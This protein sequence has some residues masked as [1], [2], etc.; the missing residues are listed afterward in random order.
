MARLFDNFELFMKLLVFFA[1]SDQETSFFFKINFWEDISPFLG[2]TDTRVSCVLSR[3]ETS[4][5]MEFNCKYILK[6]TLSY[7]T[8]QQIKVYLFSTVKEL[9]LFYR[10]SALLS[11]DTCEVPRNR[12]ADIARDTWRRISQG[13]FN[14]RDLFRKDKGRPEDSEIPTVD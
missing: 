8:N 9:I 6:E 7:Q 4:L 5:T 12:W 11:S 1:Q 13:R 3:K 2:A 10:L 14:V